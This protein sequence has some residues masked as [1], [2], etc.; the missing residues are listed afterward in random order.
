MKADTEAIAK[1]FWMRAIPQTACSEK[2][3]PKNIKGIVYYGDELSTPTTSGHTYTDGCDDEA[4][5]DLTP[6]VSKTVS[7]SPF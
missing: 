2:K 3:S 1:E 6:L 4:M 5:S 7:T